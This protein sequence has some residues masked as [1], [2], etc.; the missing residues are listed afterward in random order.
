[1]SLRVKIPEQKKQADT[2]TTIADVNVDA[3]KK[4]VKNQG[5]LISLPVEKVMEKKTQ[6]GKRIIK[7]CVVQTNFKD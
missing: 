4:H 1:M 3:R 6:K 5:A 7:K 2:K